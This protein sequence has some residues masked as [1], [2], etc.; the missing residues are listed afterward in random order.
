LTSATGTLPLISAAAWAVPELLFEID[1]AE[2]RL[3]GRAQ[4][5]GE[6]G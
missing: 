3:F 4:T 2:E 5:A 6:A 1:P